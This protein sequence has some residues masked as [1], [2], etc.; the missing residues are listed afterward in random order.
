MKEKGDTHIVIE[1]GKI[2]YQFSARFKMED[3]GTF[4]WYIPSF[5]MF[6]SS[7]TKEQGDIRARAMAKSFF[8][9]YLTNEKSFR[10]FILELHNL[11][12]R[13]PLNHDLT[14][15]KLLTK[16]LSYAKFNS[17]I[18]SIPKEF[19]DSENIINQDDLAMAL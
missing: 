13:A 9:H 3:N 17:R 5:K 18:V 10:N 2:S 11:G 19:Q 15:N 14:V 12:F 7:K 6:F 4:S 1:E 16:R 8:V